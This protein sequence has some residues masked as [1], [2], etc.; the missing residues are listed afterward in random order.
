MT[1]DVI[2]VNFLHTSSTILL[3]TLK[4]IYEYGASTVVYTFYYLAFMTLLN[5]I[6]LLSSTA[7]IIN[8][9]NKYTWYSLKN[10]FQMI[11]CISYKIFHFYWDVSQNGDNLLRL[12]WLH[13]TSQNKIIWNIVNF[14]NCS[15][16]KTLPIIFVY[17]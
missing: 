11:L 2:E 12:C 8:D 10:N 6:N 5:Y 17:F 9:Q 3:G 7:V 4:T 13:W 15:G 14:K 16:K 1:T